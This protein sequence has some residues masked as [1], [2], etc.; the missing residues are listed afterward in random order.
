MSDRHRVVGH[1]HRHQVHVLLVAD[2]TDLLQSGHVDLQIAVDKTEGRVEISA[3]VSEE[4]A[5]AL[6][7]KDPLAREGLAVVP[8][9]IA[10]ARFEPATFRIRERSVPIF[11]V[12]RVSNKPAGLFER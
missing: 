2:A 9:D 5:K 11:R 8:R 3:T 6:N 4:V 12:L 7:T 1:H 10:G